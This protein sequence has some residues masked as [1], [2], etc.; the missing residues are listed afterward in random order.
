[1]ANHELI[2]TSVG[3]V[4]RLS[5]L[6]RRSRLIER[7]ILAAL[8]KLLL[9]MMGYAWWLNR[10]VQRIAALTIHAYDI[11][12][13]SETRLCPGDTLVYEYTLHSDL[14]N[15]VIEV[16]SAVW[17]ESPPQTAIYSLPVR[18]IVLG[19]HEIRVQEHWIVP[20]EPVAQQVAQLRPGNY[21]RLLAFRSPG[22]RE[23]PAILAVPFQ[24]R[25]SC[26][27]LD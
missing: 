1:M 14:G 19:Q 18:A 13:I 26:A 7:L 25:E 21:V 6:E 3:S 10:S 15:A 27:Y 16:D 2:D 8:A 17:S 4:R 12:I 24:I 22:Q 9:S 5:H 11:E 20:S 23:T